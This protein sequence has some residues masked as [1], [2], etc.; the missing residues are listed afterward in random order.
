MQRDR[1]ITFQTTDGQTIRVRRM[2]PADVNQL[3]FIFKHL[4]QDTIYMRFREPAFQLTP[5]Q[6]L[7][8]ARSL[9]EAGYRKGKGFLAFADLPDHP[10]TPI[11]GA[12][13]IRVGDDAAEVAITIRDDFQRKGVGIHL[14]N[15]LIEEARRDGVRKLIAHVDANNRAVLG[16]LN[17]YQL[18]H[19]REQSGSEITFEFDLSQAPFNQPDG[20]LRKTRALAPKR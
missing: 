13:Y 3:A 7:Q 8:E 9:A 1:Y 18:P 12:R 16:L 17:R 11:G 2:L 20:F 4:S 5:L 10:G 6:V 14:M 15:I 19:H